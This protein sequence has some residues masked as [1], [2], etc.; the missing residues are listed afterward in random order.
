MNCFI[1]L[2]TE[3]TIQ[4]KRRN[5]VQANATAVVCY[6]NILVLRNQ[7]PISLKKIREALD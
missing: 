5:T 1:V 2:V 4:E 7:D 3:K 6:F